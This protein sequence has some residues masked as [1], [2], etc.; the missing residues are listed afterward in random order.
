MSYLH[1]R[2]IPVSGKKAWYREWA[3]YK[4]DRKGR[5]LPITDIDALSKYHA[6]P[7]YSTLYMYSEEDAKQII[8][9]GHSGGMDKYVPASD[10]LAIDIDSLDIEL[11]SEIETILKDYEYEEW[12]SGGKGFHFILPHELIHDTR[13]PFSHLKVVQALG[14]KADMCLYQPGRLFRLPR[15]VH[16]KTR[17]RKELIKRNAGEQIKIPLLDKP[18][19]TFTFRDTS[20]SDYKSALGSLWAFAEQGIMEGER[21]NKFWQ[22]ASTLSTAGFDLETVRG[23][24]HVINNGQDSPLDTIELNLAINSAAKGRREEAM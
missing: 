16:E 20:D 24:L 2:R 17:A 8:A 22:M 12:F 1:Q 5:M 14:I 7:G 13:L 9:A 18:E 4:Y 6:N 11:R 23:I 15:C 19:P 21:N 3:A 10:Y